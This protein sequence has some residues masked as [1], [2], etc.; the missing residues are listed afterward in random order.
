MRGLKA[1]QSGIKSGWVDA[2]APLV[3]VRYLLF[4]AGVDFSGADND[5]PQIW[6]Y[7]YSHFAALC[8]ICLV[9]EKIFQ[10]ATFHESINESNRQLPA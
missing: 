10:V 8:C 7:G 1:L 2:D 6:I 4:C 5:R 9:Y 3:G